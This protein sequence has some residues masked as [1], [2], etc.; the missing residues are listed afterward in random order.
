MLCVVACIGF[1]DLFGLFSICLGDQCLYIFFFFIVLIRYDLWLNLFLRL[2]CGLL[3]L[4]VSNL[5][6]SSNLR[7]IIG[8][9]NDLLSALLIAILLLKPSA[10]LLHEL[11]R[12]ELAGLDP[13]LFALLCR[14]ELHALFHTHSDELS[15]PVH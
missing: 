8:Y 12:Q 10:K 9:L 7:L 11:L 6:C 14:S 1:L 5:S 15:R 4:I 2:L 13:V 3:L